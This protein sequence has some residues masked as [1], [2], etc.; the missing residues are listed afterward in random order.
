MSIEVLSESLLRGKYLHC[1]PVEGVVKAK[2]LP[3]EEGLAE[4]F[5]IAIICSERRPC[6]KC[7]LR[8]Q[9]G[10]EDNHCH[11]YRGDS[12]GLYQIVGLEMDIKSDIGYE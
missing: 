8:I 6:S 2:I 3:I 10:D 4:A 12:R 5:N 7:D 11:Y 1:R 9:A